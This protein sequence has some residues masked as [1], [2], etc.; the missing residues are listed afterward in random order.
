MSSELITV[1][2]ITYK[3]GELLYETLDSVFMQDYDSIQLIVAEDGAENFTYSD[4]EE[5]IREHAS[6]NIKEYIILRA[7]KN[8][9]TV[10]NINNAIDYAKGYY[11]R[12]IAGDDAFDNE[13]VFSKQIA[14]LREY[15][16]ALFVVGNIREC[17]SEMNPGELNGFA[18]NEVEKLLDGN[19]TKLLNYVIKK[20]PALMA[21][22]ATCY[23][24]SF[25][26]VVG[27]FDECCLLIEDLPM[28]VRIYRRA[29]PFIYLDWVCVK[30]RGSVGVSAS[31]NAF[32]ARQLMYY[33]DLL[34]CYDNVFFFVKK[35]LGKVY[36]FMRRGLIAFRIDYTKLRQSGAGFA[37]K[38]LLIVKNILPIAYYCFTQF[39]RFI[40]YFSQKGKG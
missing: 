4:V 22:Q 29:V 1:I 3:H 17:D 9:G 24:A 7:E 19:K 5:Y 39:H 37:K 14:S 10:K 40:F 23:R 34:R 11:I 13:Q 32:E 38:S 16:D 20:N 31:G 27:K 36:F 18:P 30:H 8:R 26:E 21:T 2:I 6:P 33:R 28:I 12:I 25:F 15:K 35:E